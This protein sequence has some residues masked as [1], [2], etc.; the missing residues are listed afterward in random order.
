MCWEGWDPSVPARRMGASSSSRRQTYGTSRCACGGGGLRETR[1]HELT[2]DAL[3][4]VH[5]EDAQAAA[6]A[7]AFLPHLRQVLVLVPWSLV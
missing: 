5:T 6:R 2:A 7:V 3:L 4:F 1:R